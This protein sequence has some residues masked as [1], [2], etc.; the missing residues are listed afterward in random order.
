MRSPFPGV[1]PYLEDRWRDVHSSLVL[2]ARNQ[3]QPQIRPKYRAR[4]EERVV[5]D[6]SDGDRGPPTF[7]PDVKGVRS[8]SPQQR[9]PT[10]TGEAI[11]VMEPVVVRINAPSEITETFVQIIDPSG[12]GAVVT[13][14][15]FLSPSN[16]RPGPDR[17]AYLAKQR[18]L[19]AADVAFV[20]IDLLRAG[21]RTTHY[22]FAFWPERLRACPYAACVS[23]PR[24]PRHAELYGFEML[25]SLPKIRVPL[26]EGDADATLSLQGSVDAA[27]VDGAYDDTDYVPPPVPPL[28]PDDEAWADALLR[29]AGKRG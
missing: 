14:I 4:V 29:A 18:E 15:E 13:V 7:Y 1:D 19:L 28:S 25:A 3:L 17:D 6:T 8:A 26:R 11:G 20:E 16:K 10:T 24:E 22:D 23:H 2:Y 27:Y 5:L 9:S 12:G 21:R